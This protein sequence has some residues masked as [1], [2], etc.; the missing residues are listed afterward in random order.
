[1]QNLLL[2]DPDL[3][4]V[5]V[6]L[7]ALSPLLVLLKIANISRPHTHYDPFELQLYSG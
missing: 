1:M 2:H 5:D 6:E 7:L 4:G 3:S